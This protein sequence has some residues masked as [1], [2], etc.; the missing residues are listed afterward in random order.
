M[1]SNTSIKLLKW[2]TQ[3]ADWLHLVPWEWN[4]RTQKYDLRTGKRYIKWRIV[5]ITNIVL[6]L[7]GISYFF[8][9]CFLAPNI[10]MLELVFSIFIVAT[11]SISLLFQL[12]NVFEYKA[13][14]TNVNALLIFNR[15]LSKFLFLNFD[16][17]K[18]FFFG[19]KNTTFFTFFFHLVKYF[20]FNP[21][22]KDGLEV[23]MGL[24]FLGTQLSAI[25]IFPTILYTLQNDIFNGLWPLGGRYFFL[26][27][28]I[29]LLLG[30]GF[31]VD[32]NFIVSYCF[33]LLM[34]VNSG[35]KWLKVLTISW[36]VL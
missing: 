31:A 21:N 10:V 7:L 14:N 24:M 20:E 4:N 25:S 12:I 29:T 8:L 34:N 6:R 27:A 22:D 1:L 23:I 32:W 33:V 13:I 18:Y 11:I 3:L 26:D 9:I 15:K 30:V 19:L 35:F 16:L 2:E 17:K 28:L 5:S 36:Y